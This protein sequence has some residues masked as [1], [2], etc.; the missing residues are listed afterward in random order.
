MG[1]T[2]YLIVLL[3]W[4]SLM[5]NHEIVL[6]IILQSGWLLLLFL[7]KLFCKL[8]YSSTI[9]FCTNELPILLHLTVIWNNNCHFFTLRE[10]QV[11]QNSD[12]CFAS[13]L[14]IPSRQLRKEQTHFIVN[15]VCSTL[16]RS[17]NNCS[18]LRMQTAIFK[19]AAEQREVG[20]R[21]S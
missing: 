7:D 21:T 1:V 13:V 9:I 5:T 6:L 3:I 20:K 10:F 12:T 17:R 2:Q 4:T 16:F 15:K 18:T 8:I 19:S 11:K 14:H